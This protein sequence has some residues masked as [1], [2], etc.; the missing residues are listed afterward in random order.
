[1]LVPAVY[2]VIWNLFP[3]PIS[4]LSP[5]SLHAGGKSSARVASVR[6]TIVHERFTEPG[7]SEAVVDEMLGIWPDAQVRAPIV[8][9]RALPSRLASS[10]LRSTW[11][12]HLYLGGPRY[13]HLLPLLPV[14]MSSIDTSGSDVVIGSHHAFANRVRVA[15]GTPFVLYTHTPARWMYEAT[16]REDEPGGLVGRS[17]LATFAAFER[18]RDRAAAQRVTTI[19]ANSSAVA[20]RIEKYW[21][22]RAQVLHPPVDVDYYQ[23]PTQLSSPSQYFL[24]AG[25]LVPYKR[26]DVAVMAARKVGAPL[27]V[28]G[29]GRSRSQLEKLAGPATHFLGRV[30]RAELRTLMQGAQAL[31]FPGIE[32]FGIVPVE[33]MACGTPVIAQSGG[34]VLDSVIPGRTG[35]LYVPNDDPVT[36]LG[37]E[38]RRFD[39]GVFD[40]SIIRGQAQRFSAT[41]FR[42]NLRRHVEKVVAQR[43]EVRH[44]RC[45]KRSRRSRTDAT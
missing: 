17:L 36:A 13:A 30:S 38:L 15:D 34:G 2:A 44:P 37:G 42:D 26:P 32:D 16:M 27:T 28:I 18:P 21:R 35:V 1:M 39:R 8:D 33:A 7:G 11:L 22:R 14:A 43:V 12:Q 6:I 45:R 9:R 3:V 4:V 5:P 25:R 40:S 19:L 29:E 23:P 24:M 10:Q 20:A 41:N 31:L